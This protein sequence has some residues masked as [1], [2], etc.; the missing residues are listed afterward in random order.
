M[1]IQVF[2]LLKNWKIENRGKYVKKFEIQYVEKNG[3][4]QVG[5]DM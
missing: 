5:N 2:L 3:L 1:K 4:S